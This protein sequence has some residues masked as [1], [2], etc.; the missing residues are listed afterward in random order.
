[1]YNTKIHEAIVGVRYH[2]YQG[3]QQ[4]IQCCA[5]D[6]PVDSAGAGGILSHTDSGLSSTY[7]GLSWITRVHG[8]IH[9]STHMRSHSKMLLPGPSLQTQRP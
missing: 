5:T 9:I 2:R 1:M 3:L 4:F 6:P 7:A 8:S